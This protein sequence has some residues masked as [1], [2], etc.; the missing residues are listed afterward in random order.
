M[1]KILIVMLAATLAVSVMACGKKKAVVKT[2]SDKETSVKGQQDTDEETTKEVTPTDDNGQLEPKSKD[3]KY[4]H[5]GIQTIAYQSNKRM[6]ASETFDVP[7]FTDE[8]EKR[9]YA[10]LAEA[11]EKYTQV[12]TSR[13]D[14]SFQQLVEVGENDYDSYGGQLPYERL[15]ENSQMLFTRSDENIVSC[16][17]HDE[18]Y[19]GGAHGGTFVSGVSFDT[20]TG[21]ELT[22]GDVVKDRNQFLDLL[23]DRL[24]KEYADDYD[25]FE[26]ADEYFEK[27]KNNTE[28]DPAWYM[29]S[30]SVVVIFNEYDLGPFAVGWQEVHMYFD[31]YADSINTKYMTVPEN[32]I[33]PLNQSFTC[34]IDVDGDGSRD[35]FRIIGGAQNSEE[36]YY[37]TVEC[38]GKTLK[39]Q[40]GAY[41]TKGFIVFCNNQ[42]YL[43]IFE[44]MAVENS[45]RVS[46]VDLKNMTCDEER[47]AFVI[48]RILY[49]ES[50]TLE[51]R[52]LSID[53]VISMINPEDMQFDSRM[54]MLSTYQG[55]RTYY[56]DKEGHFVPRDKVYYPNRKIEL[57]TKQ[58]ISC[59]LVDKD[60]K[61]VSQTT[62][63]KNSAIK[64]VRTD[65]DTWADVQ[66]TSPEGNADA[67]NTDNTFI[68]DYN[69][70]LYDEG[71][72]IYRIEVNMESWPHTIN[73]MNEEDVLQGTQYAG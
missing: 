63:P 40:S 47:A 29:D 18:E 7:I 42:Y 58:D 71:E 13:R 19:L 33:I 38:N 12:R 72:P 24:K 4:L 73:G 56:M 3:L 46:V 28:L 66:L 9:E 61:T 52:F 21:K 68:Y 23:Q 62:L 16:C 54:D 2:D 22:L 44:D 8:S 64:I 65:G 5:M 1:K 57:F 20:A 11:I 49:S 60:G 48:Q 34:K 26:N 41:N 69:V 35:D 17:I 37:N 67:K 59:E 30:E 53:N 15:Y 51:D 45:N 43:M 36:I 10:K 6:D 39:L 55:Y 70:N 31:E 25:E 50:R 27:M 32:Y 14:E